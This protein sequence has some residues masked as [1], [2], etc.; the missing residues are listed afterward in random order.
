MSTHNTRTH[1]RGGNGE[2]GYY[3]FS[4]KQTFSTSET[5]LVNEC[6]IHMKAANTEGNAQGSTRLQFWC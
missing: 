2:A 5:L 4:R 3:F 6:R 1:K